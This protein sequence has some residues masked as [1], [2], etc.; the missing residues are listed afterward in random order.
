MKIDH[1]GYAVNSIEKA[2]QTLEKL[3]YVFGPTIR[4]EKRNVS[5][6]FGKAGGCKY[7]TGSANVRGITGRFIPFQARPDALS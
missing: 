4:D 5:L 1:I 6:A 2:E 7:R 3:G